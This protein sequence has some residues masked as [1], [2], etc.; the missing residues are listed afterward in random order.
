MRRLHRYIILVPAV[1]LLLCVVGCGDSGAATD[2]S[3]SVTSAPGGATA[4]PTLAPDKLAALESRVQEWSTLLESLWESS[5]DKTPDI[6]AFLWPRE[7]AEIRAADY[8]RTWSEGSDGTGGVYAP[9]FDHIAQVTVGGEGTDAV[10]TIVNTI[11]GLDGSLTQGLDLVTWTYQ[12]R[13]WYRTTSFWV[14]IPADGARQA[15][16]KTIS[17]GHMTWSAVSVEETATLVAGGEGPKGG[18]V[19]L[20]V[21]LYVYNGGED[22][23]T[24]FA[25][26]VKLYD[27]NGVELATAKAFDAEFPGSAAARQVLLDPG[28]ETQLQYCFEAPSGVELTGLQYEVVPLK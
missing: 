10:L 12:Q 2:S 8:Q 7:E 22:N 20:V 14:P 24:P 25:Y 28:M 15:L 3:Q 1:A 16:D 13:Q 9:R 18:G 4:S 6:A 5:A 26:T 19:F 11:S 27:A 23:G 21:S 17:A